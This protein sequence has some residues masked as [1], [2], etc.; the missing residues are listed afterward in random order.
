MT[1]IFVGNLSF[2]TSDD[3]LRQ[4]FEQYGTVHSAAVVM[5]KFTGNPRGFGF[6]EMDDDAAQRAISGVNGQSV[7][8]RNLTV[9]VARPR[10]ERPQ[11]FGGGGGGRGGHEGGGRGRGSYGR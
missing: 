9:N 6:V 1:K 4:L 8:G 5:D 7:D 10:E 11:R 3:Q 2:H